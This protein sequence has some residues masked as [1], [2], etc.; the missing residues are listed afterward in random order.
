MLKEL[1]TYT[2]ADHEVEL[3]PLLEDEARR[4]KEVCGTREALGAYLAQWAALVIATPS[5]R[6]RKTNR[7]PLP[8]DEAAVS[9]YAAFHAKCAAEFLWNSD[10]ALEQWFEEVDRYRS[11]D[12]A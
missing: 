6:K 3:W 9:A 8:A 5:R 4:M 12:L 11:G 7:Y 10:E 2:S 1:G